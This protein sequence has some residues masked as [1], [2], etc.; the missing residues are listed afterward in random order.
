MLQSCGV[1]DRWPTAANGLTM[2]D[3]ASDR[4]SLRQIP[5]RVKSV[6]AFVRSSVRPFV[7]RRRKMSTSSQI[8]DGD[9][10]VSER[11]DVAMLRPQGAGVGVPAS[12]MDSSIIIREVASGRWMINGGWG[13]GDGERASVCYSILNYPA[14]GPGR[15]GTH[16]RGP[17]KNTDTPR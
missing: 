2:P 14:I 1:A 5:F 15:I 11:A 4:V 3:I 9:E 13:M 10:L 7:C 6:R 12:R 17:K 16:P 8:A